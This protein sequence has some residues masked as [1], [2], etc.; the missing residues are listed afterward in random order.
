MDE[1]LSS[2]KFWHFSLNDHAM[3]DFPAFFHKIKMV[4]L[5][6]GVQDYKL[7]VTSH[8]LGAAVTMMYLVFR[9]LDLV[10][11]PIG[12]DEL[13]LS[14]TSNSMNQSVLYKEGDSREGEEG[15]EDE[16]A[17]NDDHVV[18]AV[19]LSPAGCHEK[20]P[21]MIYFAIPLVET[22]LFLLPLYVFKAPTR[23]FG[24]L[25]AKLWEDVKQ[26]PTAKFILGLFTA[27][28]LG[29]EAE[30]HPI[31]SVQPQ[32]VFE[33]TSVTIYRHFVQIWR[34]GQFQAFDYGAKEN[35]KLYGSTEPLPMFPNYK[36]VDV[37]VSFGYGSDDLLIPPENIKAHYKALKA[38]HP[39]LASLQA[40]DTGHLVTLIYYHF[41]FLFFYIALFR[42]LRLG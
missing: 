22:L 37:P 1:N 34:A 18:S 20:H 19:L 10:K 38:V 39:D 21:K 14:S 7:T 42:S 27:L 28:L 11:K 9:K 36:L 26:T 2:R 40:F 15:N 3:Y 23:G 6:E 5:S 41:F 33:G 29:G 32:H 17:E 25:M 30:N 24:K 16:D 12:F 31:H 8:S 4:K 35:L 13:D